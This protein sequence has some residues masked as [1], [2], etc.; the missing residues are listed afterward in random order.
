MATSM[1]PA[2]VSLSKFNAA[3][4]TER[5]DTRS[6]YSSDVITSVNT[7][8]LVTGHAEVITLG[9]LV[10]AS[11]QGTT[12]KTSAD[13]VFRLTESYRPWKEFKFPYYLG[14]TLYMGYVRDDG[15][16]FFS[17]LNTTEYINAYFVSTAI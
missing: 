17:T 9:K 5:F 12:S 16:V 14:N 4:S 6:S 11:V 2:Y 8:F 10:I 13:W 15:Y 3:I 1:I 7:N